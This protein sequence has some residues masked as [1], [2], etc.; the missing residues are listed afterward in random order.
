M[1]APSFFR[2][3]KWRST[4]RV[5]IEHPPGKE[6]LAFLYFVNK[7]PRT[8]TPARIVLTNL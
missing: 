3:N 1:F 8:K 2:A 7:E 6:T 5:P 4:G